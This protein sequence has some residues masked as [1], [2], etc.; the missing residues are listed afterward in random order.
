MPSCVWARNLSNDTVQARAGL[1][2]H[3]G[4]G[5]GGGEIVEKFFFFFGLWCLGD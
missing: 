4:G 2:R 1:L 5:G 3:G